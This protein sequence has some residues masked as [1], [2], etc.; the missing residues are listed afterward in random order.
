M[1]GFKMVNPLHLSCRHLR[2]SGYHNL[3]WDRANVGDRKIAR[4]IGFIGL[5]LVPKIEAFGIR[6]VTR[7]PWSTLHSTAIEDHRWLEADQNA[8]NWVPIRINN[9]AGECA[10]GVLSDAGVTM[11]QVKGRKSRR[12]VSGCV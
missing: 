3:N 1:V 2:F 9:A 4:F 10:C 6:N 5:R 7:S 11:P 12:E 8:S